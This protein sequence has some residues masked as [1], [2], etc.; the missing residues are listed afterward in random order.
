MRFH[1][2][3]AK[4]PNISSYSGECVAR[5]A[6]FV[7]F[8]NPRVQAVAYA[9]GIAGSPKGCSNDS[10][11]S[12]AV[13][14]RFVI[15][16]KNSCLAISDKGTVALDIQSRY[17]LAVDRHRASCITASC[18]GNISI[19]QRHNN[20]IIPIGIVIASNV[21]ASNSVAIVSDVDIAVLQRH[22]TVSLGTDGNRKHR[23]CQRNR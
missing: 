17:G 8:S 19:P 7:L 16:I 3:I 14:P 22:R 5:E 9:L 23:R 20:R 6:V 18:N 2:D 11:L 4:S 21:N 12:V 1:F 13:T 15:C 10:A